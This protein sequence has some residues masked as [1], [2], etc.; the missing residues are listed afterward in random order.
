MFFH[1]IK[2]ILEVNNSM[3]QIKNELESLGSWGDQIEERISNLDNRN[4]EMTQER[5]NFKR[6][7]KAYKSSQTWEKQI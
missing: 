6:I 7:K 3:N 2:K 1:Q 5:E 4:L